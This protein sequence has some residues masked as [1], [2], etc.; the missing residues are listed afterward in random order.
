MHTAE[1]V[2]NHRVAANRSNLIR[3]KLLHNRT[4]GHAAGRKDFEPVIKNIYMNFAADFG[5]I[6]VNKGINNRLMN[7]LFRIVRHLYS[8]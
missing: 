8:A 6:T 4:V 2:G 1:Q 7:S 5:I 3:I